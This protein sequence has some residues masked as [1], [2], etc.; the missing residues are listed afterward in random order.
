M[1]RRP[2]L[3]PLFLPSSRATIRRVNF[4]EK[5]G[6]LIAIVFTAVAVLA[7][8]GMVH[9]WLTEDGTYRRA[10]IV[11][12]SISYLL[13]AVGAGALQSNYG[14]L[15]LGALGFCFL[16]DIFGPGNFLLGV[17]MFLLAHLLFVPAFI[18]RGVSRRALTVSLAA[19]AL[20]TTA[21]TIYLGSQIPPDERL[22]IYA[23]AAVIALMLG[24]A[25]G[26]LGTGSR[27]LVPLAALVFYISDLF[28]AQT[29]FLGGGRIWTVTGYP[30][31][32]TACVLFAWS[33][34]GQRASDAR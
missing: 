2:G 5:Y 3:P 14:R 31:Y 16:G 27:G 11:T 1:A 21:V 22:L 12:A 28:L 25:G 19:S 20:L 17:V 10:F 32:Y 7:V 6:R 4:Q 15:V 13:V 18:V 30:L 29:A 34:T 8:V 26:T 33:A 24:V 23:Y 9:S